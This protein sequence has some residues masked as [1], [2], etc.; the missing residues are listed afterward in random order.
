MTLRNYFLKREIILTD[1]ENEESTCKKESA[2]LFKMSQPS[3][4]EIKE[5][6]RLKTLTPNK[7]LSRL[8]TLLAQIKVET[9]SNKLENKIRQILYLCINTVKSPKKAY[10]NLNN[11]L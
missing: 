5:G 6:K 4:E 2:D 3:D 1:F 8:P 7:S 10:N 9:N 11:F